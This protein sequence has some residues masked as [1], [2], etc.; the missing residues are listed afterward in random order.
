MNDLKALKDEI[1][2]FS[3]TSQLQSASLWMKLSGDFMMYRFEKCPSKLRADLRSLYHAL[4]YANW[5]L[6]VE[7]YLENEE[8]IK[9]FGKLQKEKVLPTGYKEQD[10]WLDIYYLISNR[11]NQIQLKK[12]T[13]KDHPVVIK[14]EK[15]CMKAVVNI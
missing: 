10:I 15:M 7:V 8:I 14:A 11:L 13:T 1:Y 12:I 6:K 2:I 3:V 4:V 5:L 9:Y